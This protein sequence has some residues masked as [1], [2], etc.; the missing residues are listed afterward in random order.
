MQRRMSVMS[1][2]LVYSLLKK[3]LRFE[4]IQVPLRN[5]VLVLPVLPKCRAGRVGHTSNHSECTSF[6][7]G[8]R[9]TRSCFRKGEIRL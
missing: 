9:C 2:R 1:G 7:E 4:L 3:K 8:V 6:G 5:G